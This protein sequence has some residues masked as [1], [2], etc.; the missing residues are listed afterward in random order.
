[1]RLRV[2]SSSSFSP[3]TFSVL[4]LAVCIFSGTAVIAPP[5]P[6]QELG[7]LNSP[8]PI[9]L[10]EVLDIY[11]KGTGMRFLT[12]GP[13]RFCKNPKVADF[14][15]SPPTRAPSSKTIGKV[16]FASEAKLSTA[17]VEARAYAEGAPYP[18]PGSDSYLRYLNNVMD[19]LHMVSGVISVDSMKL[20]EKELM[21]L[22]GES[23]ISDDHTDQKLGSSDISKPPSSSLIVLWEVA[24][25]NGKGTGVRFLTI[26]P[27]RF[28]KDRKVADAG[29]PP[30]RLGSKTI[31]G[32]AHFES[33]GEKLSTVFD[34]ARTYAKGCQYANP[35]SDSLNY[36][37]YLDN[38]MEHLYNRKPRAI[39]DQTRKLWKEELKQ[40]K[41]L[42]GESILF[43]EYAKFTH[44]TGN[45]SIQIGDEPVLS[46]FPPPTLTDQHGWK[47]RSIILGLIEKHAQFDRDEVRKYA[48]SHSGYCGTEADVERFEAKAA[49]WLQKPQSRMSEALAEWRFADGVMDFLA[50]RGFVSKETL[51]TWD[52]QC[53]NRMDIFI[54]RFGHPVEDASQIAAEKQRKDDLK[55]SQALARGEIVLNVDI[56]ETKPIGKASVQFDSDEVLSLTAPSTVAGP[57]DWIKCEVLGPVDKNVRVN[58]NEVREYAKSKHSKYCGTKADIQR[59]KAK[60]VAWQRK[61][62]SWMLKAL[63]EWRFADGVMEFLAVRGFV[64]KEALATW[65]AQCPKDI[66]RIIATIEGRRFDDIEDTERAP[67]R[68]KLKG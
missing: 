41:V 42:D 14:V 23:I 34:E 11:G 25:T 52:K 67:K 37:T 5:L 64:S 33:E 3:H 47:S 63:A 31:I 39:D 53:P 45:S 27:K 56:R 65:N 6:N 60:E 62:D 51:A 19:Y 50:T 17:F 30:T 7:H 8:T 68:Q 28:C 26:G 57:K 22:G 1:M 61:P 35:K 49:V 46:L 24:N 66:D 10:S 16:T 15:T 44:T 2:L 43:N 20:W 21:D 18:M 48:Q 32:Y 58:L 13:E 9:I 54:L 38:V 29:R 40:L 12:I 36:L 59:F 4:C 55:R